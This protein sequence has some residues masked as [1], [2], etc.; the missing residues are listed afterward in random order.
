MWYLHYFDYSQHKNIYIYTF[1]QTVFKALSIIGCNII[2]QTK[3]PL[4]LLFSK[5]FI[6]PPF[7]LL[8]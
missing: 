6:F 7:F 4:P 8:A 3:K 5:H 1:K 2:T